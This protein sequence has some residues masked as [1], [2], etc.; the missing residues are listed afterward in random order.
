M[1]F[2]Y[3]HRLAPKYAP[4][5]T[6][7]LIDLEVTP[8]KQ[9]LNLLKDENELRQRI[10]KAAKLIEKTSLAE[11]AKQGAPGANST[12]PSQAG[13]PAMPARNGNLAGANQ[14]ARVMGTAPNQANNLKN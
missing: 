10:N 12:G 13:G 8:I 5:I 14:G 1:F 9:I 7:M 3:V 6:G 11:S 2:P 4:K